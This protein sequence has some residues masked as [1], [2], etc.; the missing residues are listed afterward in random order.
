[1][2]KTS[3]F[4]CL[5]F[6]TGLFAL[7]VSAADVTYY[8]KPGATDWADPSSFCM[9]SARTVPA[10]KA[11]SE[12]DIVETV[13]DTTYE[14]DSTGPSFGVFA[15]LSKILIADRVVLAIAVAEGTATASPIIRAGT[16]SSVTT[17]TIRKKG[18]GTLVLATDTVSQLSYPDNLDVQG[19]TLSIFPDHNGN[20]DFF[21]GN[22]TVAS[23]ATLSLPWSRAAGSRTNF[24]SINVAAG[25]IVTNAT[26]REGGH[27][28]GFH[29]YSPT[30]RPA[31]VIA[32]TLAGNV[33][34]RGERDILLCGTNATHRQVVALD[35]GVVAVSTFAAGS[36]TPLGDVANLWS[37]SGG[38]G[39]AFAGTEAETVTRDFEVGVGKTGFAT[40][41]SGAVGITYA[42]NWIPSVAGGLSAGVR[43]LA[44][45]GSNQTEAVMSGD[46]KTL[47]SDGIS[48]PFSIS[49][50]GSGIWRLDD[51]LARF[52]PNVWRIFGG[53]LR[54]D[55]LAA[56]GVPCSLGTAR[57]LTADSATAIDD[58]DY[59]PYSFLLGGEDAVLENVSAKP[60]YATGRTVALDGA[61]GHLRSSNSQPWE[62]A[63]VSSVTANATP[64]LTLDGSGTSEG[65]I[66]RDITDGADG[67]KVSVAKEGAGTWRIGGKL[68]FSGDLNVKEGTLQIENPQGTREQRPFEYY[69]I[70]FAQVGDGSASHDIQL[71]Q[72]CLFDADGNRLN[73][74]LKALLGDTRQK[75]QH[76]VYVPVRIPAGYA[77][78]DPS[79]EGHYVNTTHEEEFESC[80]NEINGYGSPGNEY[81]VTLQTK[82]GGACV[83]TPNDPDTWIR[84][85]MHLPEGS[86]PVSYFDIQGV[87]GWAYLPT[88]LKLEGSCDGQ[89]W[90]EVWGNVESGTP[91]S[92]RVTYSGYN[93]WLSDGSAASN[94]SHARP[95]AS[96]RWHL[97]ASS[98][99]FYRA[100]NWFRLSFAQIGYGD[101]VGNYLRIREICL[102]DRFGNR[103]NTNLVPLINQETALPKNTHPAYVADAIRPGEAGYDPSVSGLK[104]MACPSGNQSTQ[105]FGASF[106]GR[107]ADNEGVWDMKWLDAS[108]NAL[109]P[110]SGD[111][112]SWIPIVMH[113][114]DGSEPITH[115]DIQ[116]CN[117]VQ[118]MLN[119]WPTRLMLEGSCDGVHWTVV[120][121]NATKGDAYDYSHYGSGS[122]YGVDNNCLWLSDG[123]RCNDS[124]RSTYHKRLLGDGSWT[125]ATSWEL[126]EGPYE[127]LEY[128][129]VQVSGGLLTTASPLTISKFR[130][131]ATRGGTLDNFVF[132]ENGTLDIVGSDI[133]SGMVLPGTYTNCTGLEN[134][135]G[136]TLTLNGKP[137]RC[138]LAFNDGKLT[139]LRPGVMIIVR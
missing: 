107:F 55:S 74:T 50:T 12:G 49:K 28:L 56:K 79:M 26:T 129:T 78:Y 43:R 71:R 4:R 91:L 52:Y 104:V 95:P 8:F 47:Q 101:A 72:I 89:H 106:G 92:E 21:F 85:I 17:G 59:V 54:F 1:M 22:I 83:M 100:F 67:A 77:G 18:A 137:T 108:G 2:F 93:K 128:A 105:E 7:A 66:V 125:L 38:G 44:L 123:A 45:A 139:L 30:P 94:D 130:I 32:G 103:Q 35:G 31:S 86:A 119:N 90:K 34:L 63:G 76:K 110:T 61:G 48:Y 122:G 68:T 118:D 133:P 114:A 82:S 65:N 88:R 121:D 6:I 41:G 29:S 14:I 20:N 51:T 16:E 69:R 99:D 46:I 37:Y 102:F 117:T 40:L 98:G 33:R 19:G 10:T 70:S 62:M 115:F 97:S 58:G 109:N 116:S 25:G 120:H 134:L 80:F 138:T 60:A 42:G 27:D 87:A 9:D 53:T 15:N 73:G 11:P 111:R 75:G 36:D 3:A 57:T 126:P 5:A 24:H 135:V 112:F 113:L 23:G 13:A 81:G 84:I 96:T 124:G 39:Y 132:A 127:Q 64:T 136:W 131:D